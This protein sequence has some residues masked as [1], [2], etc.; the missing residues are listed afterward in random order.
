VTL[1]KKLGIWGKNKIVGEDG[2]FHASDY[3]CVG[4]Y[5]DKREV[6][7]EGFFPVFDVDI[8]VFPYCNKCI[9]KMRINIILD[10]VDPHWAD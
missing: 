4:C 7:A 9:E 10:T 3:Y 1:D 5:Q 6:P 8:P 2:K